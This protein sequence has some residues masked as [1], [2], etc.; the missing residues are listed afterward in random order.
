MEG[1]RAKERGRARGKWGRKSMGTEKGIDGRNFFIDARSIGCC[2][3]VDPSST[4]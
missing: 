1:R 4:N 2:S 3:Y